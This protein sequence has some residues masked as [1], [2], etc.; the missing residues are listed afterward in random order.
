MN[1]EILRCLR[2]SSLPASWLACNHLEAPRSAREPA[3][4]RAHTLAPVARKLTTVM[5][6]ELQ[7]P[8]GGWH[9]S[10]EVQ[11]SV[12]GL[13]GVFYFSDVIVFIAELHKV[14]IC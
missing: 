12:W 11:G 4:T 10:L 2:Q 13:F 1:L 7:V 8:Q 3:K 14:V 9:L 5:G 6:S